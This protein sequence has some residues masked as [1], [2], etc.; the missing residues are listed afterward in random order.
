MPLKRNGIGPIHST[1][2][3]VHIFIVAN[4]GPR[5]FPDVCAVEM[6]APPPI[7][8]F[9][10]HTSFPDPTSR[11]S[12]FPPLLLL[13]KQTDDD[14]I[15]R[16]RQ[17]AHRE[18]A[19]FRRAVQADRSYDVRLHGGSGLWLVPVQEKQEAAAAGESF[20]ASNLL[21]TRRKLLVDV[22]EK[23][24]GRGAYFRSY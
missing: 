16:D 22:G 24:S 20:W 7:P 1:Q 12:L 5:H 21:A 23:E 17:R 6:S 15:H 8:A 14:D 10:N 9:D 13:E 11:S 4:V 18:G 19:P 2:S 3:R